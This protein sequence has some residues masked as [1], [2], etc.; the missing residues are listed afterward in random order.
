MSA[1]FRPFA[2]ANS[3][4]VVPC[5]LADCHW[6]QSLE[7]TMGSFVVGAPRF[8]CGA[9]VDTFHFCTSLKESPRAPWPE[10]HLVPDKPHKPEQFRN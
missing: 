7:S 3:F 9:N 10:A 4:F 2:T 5:P 1:V 8:F 6:S